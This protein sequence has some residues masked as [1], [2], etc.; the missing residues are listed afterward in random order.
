MILSPFFTARA[1]VG[2][3]INRCGFSNVLNHFIITHAQNDDISTSDLKSAITVVPRHV[4]L[5]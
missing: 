1:N 4:D 5:V 3:F 2:Y